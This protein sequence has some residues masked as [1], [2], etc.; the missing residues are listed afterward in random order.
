M[1]AVKISE[2]ILDSWDS[3]MLRSWGERIHKLSDM[4]LQNGKNEMRS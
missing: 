4:K 3:K 1:M 2:H